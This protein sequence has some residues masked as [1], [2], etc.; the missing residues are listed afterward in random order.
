MFCVLDKLDQLHGISCLSSLLLFLFAH[1]RTVRSE[2]E[3][4]FSSALQR[5]RVRVY[6]WH[7]L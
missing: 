3:R 5:N 6:L 2:I 1:W 4:H 7:A